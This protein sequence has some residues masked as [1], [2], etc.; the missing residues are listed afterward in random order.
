ME[1]TIPR[2]KIKSSRHTIREIQKHTIMQSYFENSYIY[3]FH[4]STF[5]S[6]NRESDN[7][8]SITF[9]N[10]D[11]FMLIFSNIVDSYQNSSKYSYTNSNSI[12]T[13]YKKKHTNLKKIL[14]LKD[15]R[16]V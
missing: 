7:N 2:K 8:I 3:S 5:Y 13:Y 14:I 6:P 9:F 4:S 11:S 10:T 1:Q 12:Y 16:V 15:N